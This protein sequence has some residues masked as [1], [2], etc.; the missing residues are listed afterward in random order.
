M[1]Y[2]GANT[3]HL[4]LLESAENVQQR[5]GLSDEEMTVLLLKVISTF[6]D[7]GDIKSN[8]ISKRREEA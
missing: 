2:F 8:E 6:V 5:F 4:A 3:P 1:A 7:P